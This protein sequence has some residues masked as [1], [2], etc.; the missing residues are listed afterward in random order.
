MSSEALIGEWGISPSAEP[1]GGRLSRCWYARLRLG[2]GLTL[3]GGR[4]VATFAPSAASCVDKLCGH[5]ELKQRL[6]QKSDARTCRT[7]PHKAA[8][9]NSR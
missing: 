9:Q 4:A 2:E 6:C 1:L 7:F 8:K 5:E 3:G